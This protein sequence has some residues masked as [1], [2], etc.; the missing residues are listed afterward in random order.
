MKKYR[1]ARNQGKAEIMTGLEVEGMGLEA[2]PEVD[3]IRK[4]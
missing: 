2:S 4:H 3:A 1:P